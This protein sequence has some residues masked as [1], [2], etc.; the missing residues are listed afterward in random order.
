M[1]QAK[2]YA[3]L[4]CLLVLLLLN[5]KLA[6]QSSVSLHLQP[7]LTNIDGFEY[8][9]FGGRAGLAFEHQFNKHWDISGGPGYYSVGNRVRQ[10]TLGN[11]HDQTETTV[12]TRLHFVDLEAVAGL[13]LGDRVR[14]SLGPYFSYLLHAGE[15]HRLVHTNNGEQS[16]TSYTENQT[17]LFRQIDYGIRPTVNVEISETLSLGVTYSQGFRQLSVLDAF[18]D[19]NQRTQALML[20]AKWKI[21]RKSH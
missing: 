9:H 14:I 12:R 11:G 6:A 5:T 8:P 4:A 20:G 17:A 2:I 16:E 13:T 1:K 3:Q 10:T 7:A 18:F 19:I 15:N 21:W